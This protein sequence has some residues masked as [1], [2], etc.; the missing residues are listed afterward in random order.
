MNS[1]VADLLGDDCALV[2]GLKAGDQL[3]LEAAGLLGVQIAHLLRAHQQGRQSACRGIPQDPPQS[4]QPAPQ[5][6]TGSFSQL[7]SPTNFPGC[8]ST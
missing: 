5:I 2:L 8:F 6:S 7:V 3:G 4:T 1:Q